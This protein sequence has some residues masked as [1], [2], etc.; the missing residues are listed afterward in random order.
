MGVA[1]FDT[2]TAAKRLRAAGFDEDQAE[3][4]VV[5]V[6]EAVTE[7]ATGTTDL[8]AGMAEL[9]TDVADIKENM[10]R[11]EARVERVEADVARVETRV[12]RIEARVERIET[13]VARIEANMENVATKEDVAVASK[14][15]SRDL[16][17]VGL[18]LAGI[19][20]L[21]FGA[22]LAMLARMLP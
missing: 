16:M 15:A 13:N 1:A 21:G 20:V 12:E 14:E 9:R 11:I 3:A 6:R 10:V 22:M 19:M 4:A 18:G 8:E 5:M 2:Y 17:R 7:G